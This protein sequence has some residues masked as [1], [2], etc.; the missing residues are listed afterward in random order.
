MS[1]FE[2]NWDVLVNSQSQA[3]A[4]ITEWGVRRTICV[5]NVNFVMQLLRE[6]RARPGLACRK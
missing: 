1:G 2:L 4:A 3:I 6:R 5:R